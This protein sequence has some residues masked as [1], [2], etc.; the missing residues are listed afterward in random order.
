M[1][2][3]Q[4]YCMSCW[5][6]FFFFFANFRQNDHKTNYGDS[7]CCQVPLKKL[8]VMHSIHQLDSILVGKDG[9]ECGEQ[10]TMGPTQQRNG[11]K[12]SK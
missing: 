12:T 5:K 2:T 8:I 4:Y 3:I 10:A 11:T 9:D 1:V 7:S 6:S